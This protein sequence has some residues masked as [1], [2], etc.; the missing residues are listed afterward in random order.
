MI[1]IQKESIIVS[2]LET[3]SQ[4]RWHNGNIGFN[5]YTIVRIDL[6]IDK[7]ISDEIFFV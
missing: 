7:P 1:L 6:Y 2:T 4:L 5:W 3:K